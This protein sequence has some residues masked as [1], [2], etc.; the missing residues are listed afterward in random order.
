[1]QNYYQALKTRHREERA[2]YPENLNLRIHRALSWL[3]R[4]EQ[5]TD[6]DS[7][8]IF[9]WVAFNAAY[10]TEIDDHKGPGEQKIFNAF[11]QKLHTLDTNKRLD[12]LVWQAYPGSIRML[13][14]N[15][16]TFSS[17]WEYQKG[18]LT[19]AQWTRSFEGAKKTANTALSVQDTPTVLA[20][21]LSR[22]YTLR[23]QLIHGG[24][25]WGSKVNR[26]QIRDC[27][28]FMDELAP[29]VIEIMM[30]S[31]GTLWGDAAY[32]VVE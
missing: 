20:I 31:P 7:R 5:E 23:N 8:F 14:D 16:Y 21:V 24:A 9:L 1:M 15:R 13:L 19:E 6:P 22:I 17:F 26:N 30:D 11:L 4:A 32:P 10:A 3:Q 18:N 29:L 28:Q 25:T 12:E 27:V 2:N